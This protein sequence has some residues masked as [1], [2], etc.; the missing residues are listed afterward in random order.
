MLGV[1]KDVDLAGARACN[2]IIMFMHFKI[3]VSRFRVSI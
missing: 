3:P 2:P 1:G